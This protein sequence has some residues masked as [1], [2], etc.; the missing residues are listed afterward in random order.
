MVALMPVGDDTLQERQSASTF[1]GEIANGLWSQLIRGGTLGI[2]E[3]LDGD[4]S[5][6]ELALVSNDHGIAQPWQLVLR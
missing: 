3:S 2:D 5:R 6:E 1:G 4:K